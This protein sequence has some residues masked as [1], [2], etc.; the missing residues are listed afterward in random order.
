M[1]EIRVPSREGRIWN[2]RGKGEWYVWCDGH[3]KW[4]KV[5]NSYYFEGLDFEYQSRRNFLRWQTSQHGG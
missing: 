5:A 2:R 3:G 1:I 4:Q